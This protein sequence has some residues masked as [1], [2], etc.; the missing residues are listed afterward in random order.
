MRNAENFFLQIFKKNYIFSSFTSCSFLLHTQLRDPR[1]QMI[2]RYLFHDEF[3]Q[4]DLLRLIIKYICDQNMEV[5]VN[6]MFMIC[7]YDY[8]QFDYVSSNFANC[9]DRSTTAWWSK[10]QIGILRTCSLLR[11]CCPLSWITSPP[12]PPPRRWCTLLR[13]FNRA[14]FADT[15]TVARKISWSTNRWNLRITI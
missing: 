7:G 14:S 2:M 3:L 11:L 8:E 1:L 15:I 9:R 4:N 5:C 13:K 10:L 12:A 6:V